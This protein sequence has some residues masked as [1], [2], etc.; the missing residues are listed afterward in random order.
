MAHSVGR[1]G[2]TVLMKA[3][4]AYRLRTRSSLAAVVLAV[5]FQSLAA[6]SVKA[7]PNEIWSRQLGSSGHDQGHAVTV[8]R[9]GNV[10]IG[11]SV[12]AAL[13]G[14]QHQGGVDSF[15]AK[16]DC[17]GELQWV[18]QWGDAADER[19]WE[20]EVAPDG[21]VWAAEA[22]GSWG[23]EKE[24]HLVRF[25]HCGREQ[26]RF[27]VATGSFQNIFVRDLHIDQCGCL[28][29]VATPKPY[30]TSFVGK[31]DRYG[32][33]C[34]TRTISE[35]AIDVSLMGIVTNQ[36]G[37]L[38]VAGSRNSRPVLYEFDQ[39]GREKNCSRMNELGYLTCLS[40]DVSGRP[41][42]GGWGWAYETSNPSQSPDSRL[43]PFLEVI[44]AEEGVVAQLIE[45]T[46]LLIRFNRDGTVDWSHL[47]AISALR[48]PL[49]IDV[50]Q[51]EGGLIAGFARTPESNDDGFAATF[52][53]STGVTWSNVPVETRNAYDGTT[54][55]MGGLYVVGA[56]EPD[57]S[58][59][60]QPTAG[61]NDVYIIKYRRNV[62]SVNNS[63]E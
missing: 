42:A 31:Y 21:C 40:V 46:P 14:Q 6:L 23:D 28:Y 25:D 36:F 34:W 3:M 7:D 27:Q 43:S 62:N 57:T 22:K 53:V 5:L 12:T 51:R 4:V 33:V 18:K 38:F 60:G 54:D 24:I 37:Q 26:F 16:Y 8:D 10:Y 49:A 13:P 29:V 32:H 19:V 11:G 44:S 1:F 52:A 59:N 56:T 39:S 55:G 58:L 45:V 47:A 35:T 41:V 20:L 30:G 15:V 9:C 50:D 17:S 2:S 63:R 48:H 61:K